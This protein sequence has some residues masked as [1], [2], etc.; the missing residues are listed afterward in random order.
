MDSAIVA[1]ADHAARHWSFGQGGAAGPGDDQHRTM[2][3]RMLLDTF[4]PYKPAVI[5]WPELEE[6]ARQR[7]INLPIWDIAVQ[8]EG[9]ARLRVLS[10]ARTVQDKLLREAFELMAFEE[11]RHKEVLSHL[12]RAYGIE[13]EP[14]PEYVEPKDPEWG[15]MV[16]GYSECIDSFFAFG[17][18]ELARRSGF[19]PPELVETFEPVIQEEGR[20][21]L[22]FTNW[23]ASH[24]R[25][26]PLWRRPWFFF[27]TLAVWAYLIRER[28]GLARDVSA[29]DKENAN[30]TMEGAEALG[31]EID[32][33]VLM[34]ICLAENDRRLDGYDPRLLRPTTVPRLVR[35][36]RLFIR[37][38]RKNP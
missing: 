16:M 35:L 21:I 10:Y 38:K 30:F 1:A 23:I 32:T 11:G 17:L 28:I 18:F 31:G 27:K 13:L 22:F 14:E 7:L 20:H 25:T 29:G 2:F 15:F 19:F 4:N 24:R 9:R 3:S 37:P 36:A 5:K 6:Q 33:A 8:T 12:V 26:M 34:D